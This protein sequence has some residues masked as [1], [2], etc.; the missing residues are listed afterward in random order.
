M[1]LNNIV[2]LVGGVG[3]AKLAHGLA[4]ILPP[5]SL[6][7]IVN[8]GDDFW[9]Y[10]LR[11]CPDLDTVMYTLGGLVDKTNGWGIAG[12][13]RN[14]LSALKRY[15]EEAWFGLGDQ[16]IATHLLRTQMWHEGKRL[17]EIT[18]SLT[19][20]LGISH[21]IL[22]MTDAP[23]RTIMDTEEHGEIEFQVYFVR[24]RWQPTVK[25]IR[26]DGIEAASVSPEARTALERADAILIG[27]S[28]PWLS[29][30]PILSVPGMRSLILSR[31]V[32]RVA[33]SPIVRGEAIKGP[34]AKLMSELKYEPSART[35]ADYYNEI[36]NGFVYDERDAGLN[37]NLKRIVAFDTIMVDDEDRA[38]LARRILEWIEEWS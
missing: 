4:Q 7:I 12:D 19:K 9:H 11:V 30:D 17:T 38:V 13:T 14:M 6:T 33:V 1:A 34:A 26:F 16:D 5:E 27:P 29:I 32:P 3:G 18:Q 20:R 31:D 2:V 23:V 25:A 15:G 10:G 35:V 22:P 37:L 36:I 24:Y 8:T 28:N 21:S